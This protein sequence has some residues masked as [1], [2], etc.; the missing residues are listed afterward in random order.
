VSVYISL[1]LH[2]DVLAIVWKMELQYYGKIT[3]N[4]L[5]KVLAKNTVGVPARVIESID[6]YYEKHKDE[7]SF[8]KNMTRTEKKEYL[9]K[10]M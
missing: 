1:L 4:F 8:T 6:A 5:Q 7:F 10:N 2:I 3:C 9:L